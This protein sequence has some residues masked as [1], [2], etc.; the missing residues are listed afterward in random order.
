MLEEL[1]AL[2]KRTGNPIPVKLLTIPKLSQN[3]SWR[4]IEV[5]AIT[6]Y[7]HECLYKGSYSTVLKPL[8]DYLSVVNVYALTQNQ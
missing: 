4:G 6:Q 2:A 8:G 1:Q 7:G 5:V 3:S